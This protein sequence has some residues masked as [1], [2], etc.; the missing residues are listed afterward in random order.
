MADFTSD[1]W[2]IAIA[3][4]VIVSILACA[5]LAWSLASRR[6]PVLD[7]GSVE[8]TGHV[9]DEDLV[10]LNNPLPRWWLYLFYLTCVFAALYLYL[11]PG[12]GKF[13]G[14]LDWTSAG[15]YQQEVA[16]ARAVH[17]P[18]FNQFLAKDVEDIAKDEQV[19]AMG[20]RLYLTYCSQCHGSDARGSKSFPNLTDGDWLGTGDPQYIKT[21]I[22]DGR[23]GVMPAMRAAIGGTDDD[24]AA[25][26]NYVL[27]LSGA[28]HVASLVEAGEA[29]YAI[30]AACH[31]A[32]GEGNPS[33][34]SPNL[35]D[36]IWLHG[37]S[38]A[39]VKA[40]INK[41]FDN[42]MPAFG[43]ILGEGKVHVLSAYI[44]SLSNT[45]TDKD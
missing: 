9:W 2:S 25:V 6:A 29:K 20:E 10:E 23:N 19:V 18:L 33:I 1:W 13:S 35:S 30:C 7:D 41:G 37:G 26:A 32:Q 4:V 17:E 14:S 36:D 16:D 28:S 45:G 22:T 21:T 40:A 5:L 39:S 24:V 27:S 8:S 38:K 43:E 34:G 11:Y 31:G 3:V 42:R 15:Q 44:W 12:L